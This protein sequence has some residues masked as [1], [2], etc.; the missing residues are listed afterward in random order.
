VRDD[1]AMRA[2]LRLAA[3]ARRRTS[4]WPWVGCVLVRDGEVVGA[5]ATGPFRAGHH[6]EGA[7]LEAAGER[8]RGAT[9]YVTLEPCDHDGSTPACTRLLIDAGVA[10]AVVALED[11]DPI[12]A[13]RGLARLR[14]AGVE[15]VV[16]VGAGAAARQLAPYLHHRRTGRPYVV[17]KIAATLDARVAAADGSSRWITSEEAR[18]DAHELRADS[19]AIVVGAGTAIADRPALTVR[20]VDDAPRVPPP[21]GR[22]DP[23]GRVPAAGP[24]F[25]P[26]GGPTIVVTTDAAPAE[27]VDAWTAAG[28]KVETVPPAEGG[29]GVDLGAALTLLGGGREGFVQVLVEGGGTLLG[30]VLA[31]GRAQRLVAYVAPMLLGE[32]GVPGYRFEGPATLAD[33]DRFRLVDARRLGP[34]V[35]LDYEIDSGGA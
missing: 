31:Q 6:A 33:A 32:R 24:L 25:D 22:R 27:A 16:G 26:A 13:G 20:G 5:G 1:E 18:A 2:A 11:P 28:A 12:V 29:R 17:A 10:R 23:P 30:S 9:A 15:V 35:R 4:P 3:S 19:D 14:D 21:R 34:D 8:A 7:A